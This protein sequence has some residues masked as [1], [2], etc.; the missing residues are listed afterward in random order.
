MIKII[1]ESKEKQILEL[2]LKGT[3]SD[4]KSLFDNWLFENFY[5]QHNYTIKEIIEIDLS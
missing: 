3:K 4:A 1:A 2:T 5:D